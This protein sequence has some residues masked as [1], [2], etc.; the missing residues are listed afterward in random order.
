MQSRGHGT[1]SVDSNG[2]LA[3]GGSDR[4]DPSG[5]SR[6]ETTS[7]RD[8]RGMVEST[9]R[10]RRHCRQLPPCQQECRTGTGH[11]SVPTSPLLNIL[12]QAAEQDAE[13]EQRT[14][15]GSAV[16]PLMATP[17]AIKVWIRV[18]DDVTAE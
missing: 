14:V 3:I 12:L 18:I 13:V 10:R 1:T 15:G 5:S 11:V 16:G 17:I 8:L 2:R 6:K 7:E 9:W 4:Y